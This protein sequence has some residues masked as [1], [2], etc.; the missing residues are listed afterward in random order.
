MT[1]I[2]FT[3]LATLMVQ[4][5]FLRAE[6]DDQSLLAAREAQHRAMQR[7]ID[8]MH[9]A[10]DAIVA[11]AWARGGIAIAGGAAQCVAPLGQIRERD[12]SPTYKKCEALGKGGSGLSGIAEPAGALLG[13]APKAHADTN[14]AQARNDA[15]QAE[16]RA[17]EATQ[18]RERVQR[19]TDSVLDL[20]EST[21][22]SEQ[23][24]NFAILANF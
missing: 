20:V 2:A 7:E 24:G 4:N 3:E 22:A 1:D 18:H 11:G 16:S 19:H 8:A 21:L 6:A 14:A 15:E 12:C 5:D 9:D 23:Q 13:D 17:D 10:A